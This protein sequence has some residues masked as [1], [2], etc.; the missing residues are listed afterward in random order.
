MPDFLKQIQALDTASPQAA[1][2]K[3]EPRRQRRK[4]T[5]D[6]AKTARSLGAAAA[7]VNQDATRDRTSTKK[8]GW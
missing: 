2:T 8:K 7:P 5:R 6:A 1:R 3:I 4:K